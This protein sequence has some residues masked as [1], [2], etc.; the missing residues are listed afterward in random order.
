M[1]NWPFCEAIEIRFCSL[2]NIYETWGNRQTSDDLI[3]F[4]RTMLLFIITIHF[5][6][7]YLKAPSL[8]LSLLYETIT[9]GNITARSEEIE[10]KEQEEHIS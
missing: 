8:K 1:I 9:I 3:S 4:A 10:K 2:A 7:P 6:T 5:K